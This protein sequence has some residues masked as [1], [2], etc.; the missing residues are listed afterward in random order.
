[1]QLSV[2]QARNNPQLL[3]DS[4]NTR[5]IIRNILRQVKDLKN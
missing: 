1:M 3:F 4:D 5:L 2:A